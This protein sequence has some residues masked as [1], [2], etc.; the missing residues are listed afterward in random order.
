MMPTK[1]LANRVLHAQMSTAQSAQ[2]VSG[3]SSV[4][5]ASIAHNESPVRSET[6]ARAQ[7]LQHLHRGGV[8][9]HLWTD[10]GNRSHWFHVNYDAKPGERTIPPT[11][12]RS[13]VYFAVHPL[14]QIPPHNASGNND[15][16]YISS[17]LPY[18]AAVNALYAEYDGKD[19]VWVWEY[20][21]FLPE[22]L[23]MRSQV[24]RRRAIRKAKEEAF[25]HSPQ[26]YKERALHKI[27]ELYYPPSVIID[28]GGGYHCY[29]LLRQPVP[30]DECNLS[31]LQVLQHSWVRMVAA[32]SGASDLRRVLRLP[33]T[34]NMKAGFGKHPPKVHFVRA[35]FER[36]YVL[37]ELEEAINDWL[38]SQQPQEE[39]RP[40]K[41]TP[42]PVDGGDGKDLRA[43]FNAR[44]SLVDL[45]AKHG[46]V[47]SFQSKSG[48]RLSRP[49]REKS[50]SSVTVFPARADGTPEISVHFSSSDGLYSEEF[51][52]K[53]SGKIRRQ[54]HDAFYVFVM[55]EHE[56]DWQKAY[57]SAKEIA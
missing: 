2:F 18:I 8:Y 28:S 51:I 48:T 10:A 49:G 14:S 39:S 9:S 38:F 35:D 32:D 43:A 17:Q 41:R 19:Y 23:Y 30:V 34:L 56:G 57:S 44:T 37:P 33:G 26:K 22:D 25:Y 13:N 12:Q 45:L 31:D 7:L 36:L 47:V 21:A 55:L 54:A 15:P 3:V 29:W 42:R 1:L 40:V 11:W 53:E 4:S 16:S 5:G 6:N 20:A 24:E 46:Y 52:D 27:N 50:H